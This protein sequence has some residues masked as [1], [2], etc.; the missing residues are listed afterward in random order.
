MG[1]AET[2]GRKVEYVV[3][4]SVHSVHDMRQWWYVCDCT[5]V[6]VCVVVLYSMCGGASLF[7]I[8]FALPCLP[9]GEKTQKKEGRLRSL[10]I[11]QKHS[12]SSVNQSCNRIH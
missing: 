6:M 10:P 5:V 2:G 4:Q 9:G 3:I 8:F 11:S 12:N 1:R 7:L